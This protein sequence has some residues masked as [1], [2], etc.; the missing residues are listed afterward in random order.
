MKR[1]YASACSQKRLARC[2][3]CFLFGTRVMAA[4]C[5]SSR[6]FSLPNR[7][8]FARSRAFSSRSRRFSSRRKAS[9]ASRVLIRSIATEL[10]FQPDHTLGQPVAV[11]SRFLVP[12][13]SWGGPIPI[14]GRPIKI[15]RPPGKP[16]NPGKFL[17]GV[18][19]QIPL[20]KITLAGP[21]AWASGGHRKSRNPASNPH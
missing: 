18:T 17:A 10:F 5:F 21:P 7:S 9:S 20:F 13:A 16:Q 11:R 19:S 4:S 3:A 14:L 15:D 6:V 8:T 1:K 2:G 12:A